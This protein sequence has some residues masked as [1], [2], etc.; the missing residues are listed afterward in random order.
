MTPCCIY[1]SSTV[2]KEIN[3]IMNTGV[4]EIDGN[5]FEDR[6]VS[7]ENSCERYSP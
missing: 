5:T 1:K 2:C 3:I 7:R 6:C 4:I